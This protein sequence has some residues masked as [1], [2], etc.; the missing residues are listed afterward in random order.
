MDI[1][2]DFPWFKNNPGYVYMDSAATS[3][4]PQCVIDRIVQYYSKEG[5]NTHNTDSSFAMIT[6]NAVDQARKTLANFIGANEDEVAFNSGATE[7]LNLI[8]L[9]LKQSL[10]EGDEIILTYG[11]HASNIVPWI[12]LANEMNLKIKYVGKKFQTT[13]PEDYYDVLSPKTKIVSFASG[14][15]L[16][17][18][19]FDEKKVTEIVKNYNPN[20]FVIVDATQSLLHYPINVKNVNCD[21]LVCSGHKLFGPTGVGLTY[22]RKEIQQFVD[23]IRYG[24]GMNF[25]ISIDNYQLRNDIEKYEGGTQNIA[26]ILGWKT[27]IDYM[28]NIGYKYIIKHDRELAEYARNKLS[29]IEN[30]IIYNDNIKSATI[31]FNYKDVFCQDLA[32]YLGRN[33]IIVRSGLSCAKLYCNLIDTKALVRASFTI[34]NTKEDIDYLYVVLKKFKKGDELDELF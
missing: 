4:K 23:P 14:H 29:Q 1:K 20:I 27:S 32:N 12:H 26:G 6:F 31:A 19:T 13:K 2:K 15:N 5:T 10:K 16:T 3:L 8:A 21:F 22:I 18:A 17:G 28:M 34:Y 24:G 11:E 9:G 30:I 33:K 25:S 7:G